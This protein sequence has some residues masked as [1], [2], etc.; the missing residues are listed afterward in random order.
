MNVVEGVTG[1]TAWLRIEIDNVGAK[2]ANYGCGDELVRGPHLIARWWQRLKRD[3]HEQSRGGRLLCDSVRKP[4]RRLEPGDCESPRSTKQRWNGGPPVQ[5]NECCEGRFKRHLR[6]LNCL[7]RSVFVHGA[8]RRGP[9]VAHM[10]TGFDQDWI[11]TIWSR[12]T[13]FRVLLSDWSQLA[14]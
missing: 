1:P 13:A 10:M 11:R 9:P 4:S 14:A 12:P 6:N 8:P 3:R 5:L 7:R 2:R